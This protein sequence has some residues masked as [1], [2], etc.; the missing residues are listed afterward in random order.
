M[1]SALLSGSDVAIF[2]S[3]NP[4]G[5]AV[6]KILSQMTNGLELSTRGFVI[7]DRKAAI[8]FACEQAVPGDC[9]LLLGKGHEVGQ[10]V[11]GVVIPFDDR[12]E[13]ANAIKQV[14]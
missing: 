11:N 14:G 7:K 10:E 5:E 4:R 1:G 3:D 13:L 8:K 2:T 9:V 12:V 6:E